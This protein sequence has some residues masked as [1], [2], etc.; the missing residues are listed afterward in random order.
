MVAETPLPVG[1]ERNRFV[2]LLLEPGE[3]IIR[4]G[5]SV[6][7]EHHTEDPPVIEE[8]DYSSLPPNVLSYLNPSRYCESD[9][10][11][12][13]ALAE[14][15]AMERN[16]ERV[17]SI[18]DWIHK[19]IEY[20]SGTTTS[21]STACD[22]LLQRMG[23]CRDFAHLGISFCRALGVPARY[24]SGYACEL[25]P[26]DFHGFF[27]A[28]LSGRWYLFDPTRLA[29]TAGLVRIGVGRD[30]ADAALRRSG[31]LRC[32]RPK[33]SWPKWSLMTPWHRTATRW[34]SAWREQL[35][36]TARLSDMS[37]A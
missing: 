29:P 3:T 32:S 10:L 15:G 9:R 13:F 4:Y 37:N 21:L 34:P 18:C 33:L 8:T 17:N 22:V 30:A 1:E 16:F 23:V 25:E 5:A 7:L 19:N 20:R 12:N 6:E 31:D 14:F 2:R 26:P 27:E 24:V 36:F 11:A 35:P 28:Y